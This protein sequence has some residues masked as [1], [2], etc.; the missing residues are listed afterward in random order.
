MNRRAAIPLG[1]AAL[2]VVAADGRAQAQDAVAA[3]APTY[4]DRLIDGGALTPDVS[5]GNA[6]EQDSSGWPRSFRVEAVTSRVTRDDVDL[7]ESG[8]RLGGMIDTPNFGAITVDANL[9]TAGGYGDDAGS[10]ITVYQLGLPM[11]GDWRVDNA[12]GAFNTPAVDLARNQYRFYVPSIVNNGLATEWRNNSSGLQLHASAGQPGQLG[13]IYVPTFE[14]LGGRQVSAGVQWNGDGGWSVALQGVDVDDVQPGLIMPTSS[15]TLSALSLLGA[16]AWRTPDTRVQ[17]NL[18]GSAEGDAGNQ[19]GAWLDTGLTYGRVQHMAGAFRM[20]PELVWG[21]LAM[22]SNLQGGYYRA[23]FQ[24]RQWLLDGGVDF[25]TPLEGDGSDTVFAT[26]YA[27]YQFTSRSG[28]GGGANVRDSD[29]DAWSVFGFADQENRWGIGRAQADYA[30]DDDRDS[31]QLTLDQ[32]WQT[33][34]STRLNTSVM[35]G[36][37]QLADDSTNLFGIAV[38]GGGSLWSS[39]VLDVNARWDRA[40]GDQSYD[41]VLASVALNWVIRRGWTVGGNFY[42]NRNTG[43]IPLEVGSP[44]PGEPTFINQTVDDQ[45]FYVSLRYNWQA[46]TRSAPLAGMPGSGSGSV[47]GILFLDANDNG[48]QDAGESGAA[49]VTVLLN[50]RFPAR[51]D[52][53]GRFEFSVVAA[54][55]HV[56]T[57]V[58]DNLPL[59][60]VF[61]TPGGVSVKVGVRDRAFVELPVQRMR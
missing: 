3:E 15:S 29:S 24:S 58:P 47:A 21:H 57:V 54:G 50:G 36:R 42:V 34:P 13:G 11:N 8:L 35:V 37:E 6:Q 52:G 33:P 2:C 10:L 46:G 22:P 59:P 49:N 14:D 61:P 9:R 32:T 18:L 1:L 4:Q 25:V 51:T 45:G 31:M 38:N 17:L 23:A 20:D 56:L 19:T 55:S 27:R 5:S 41:N 43:R 26:G 39:L 60:W 30:T 28:L 40:G 7:D 44:I 48:R 16:V 12:L 53:V